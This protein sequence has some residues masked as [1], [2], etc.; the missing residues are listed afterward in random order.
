M[1]GLYFLVVALSIVSCRDDNDS[2]Q[3]CPFV[4]KWCIE[5]PDSLGHC[6]I[7]GR[8]W[9]WRDDGRCFEAGFGNCVWESEDCMT[10]RVSADITP[11]VYSKEYRV[12]DV[13][14]SHLML[15][16]FASG[17]LLKI[18]FIKDE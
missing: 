11:R 7:I 16:T 18:K 14:Q 6:D 15:E 12:L 4:G 3:H 10:I 8:G 2:P 1:R 9:E 17:Q 13:S 5:D